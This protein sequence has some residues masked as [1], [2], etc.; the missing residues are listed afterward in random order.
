MT[1][2]DKVSKATWDDRPNWY[3]VSSHDRAVSVELQRELS[4]RL[5]A[6]TV[7]LPAS[8]MSLLSM[9]GEVADVI[10]SAVAA[11]SRA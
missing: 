3:V 8:H 2:N 10:R 1:F 9:P 5:N 11:I 7:E 4:T 6:H